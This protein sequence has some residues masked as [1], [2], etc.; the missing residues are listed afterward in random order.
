MTNIVYFIQAIVL[1]IVMTVF[2]I[3]PLDAASALGSF[4][5][6]M[7]GPVMGVS[8]RACKHLEMCFPGMPLAQK[9]TIISG[10]WDN[11]GRT[12]A[13]YPH[14][15]TIARSRMGIKNEDT[16]KNALNQNAG[17]IFISAHIGNWETHV[18]TLLHRHGAAAVLTYRSLNNTY[19]DGILRH[20][21][22]LGGKLKAFPKT[23]DSGKK[24]IAALKS[25]GILAILI[26]QKYNEGI[27]ADFFGMPAMTNPVFV[28][29]AQKYK[30]PLIAVQCR[31][32]NGARFELTVHDPIV[33]WDESGT[34]RP[35]ESVIADAH[36][37][38]EQWIRE[39][40]EQWLWLHRRWKPSTLKG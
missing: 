12:I 33:L 16:L 20:F 24:L 2:R 34:A 1:Y 30:C 4:M 25:K 22:T 18:P 39:T 13:E 29:L 8:K 19:A 27:K 6:R 26:D 14:L 32:L 35:V 23:R 17:C 11:L 15:E 7:I 3:L 10:M 38:L 21:R 37:I 40:P 5:G 36:K 9:K 28:Q 31:R